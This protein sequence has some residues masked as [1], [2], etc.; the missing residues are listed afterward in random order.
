MA[1]ATAQREIVRRLITIITTLWPTLDLERLDET[2]PA[3]LSLLEFHISTEHQMAARV[4]IEHYLADRAVAS[5]SSVFVPQASELNIEALRTSL[6]VTGPVAYKLAR[7]RGLTQPAASKLALVSL[8]GA[9][10][11][12]TLSGAR[13]TTLAAVAEDPEA[14][15]WARVPRANA[16][17]FCL[18]LATREGAYRTK[19][20]AT[21]SKDGKRYHDACGC[22]A[23][24]IFSDVWTPPR[25]VQRASELYAASTADVSGKAKL[26]AFDKALRQQRAA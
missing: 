21:T 11:R 26:H 2:W 19:E 9:A 24:A 4:A 12:H 16:C 8:Q 6:T 17:A 23:T 25:H 3:L 7:R 15:G 5:V 14:R 18:M 22:V 10:A 20:S 13:D 1:L